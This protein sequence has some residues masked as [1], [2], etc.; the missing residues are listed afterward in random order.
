[1]F[2]SLY[3]GL[4][5]IPVTKFKVRLLHFWLV[6]LIFSHACSTDISTPP[7]VVCSIFIS[8]LS[9]VS[10]ISRK[11]GNIFRVVVFSV[12]LP[13]LIKDFAPC[14]YSR[15]YEKTHFVFSSFDKIP[16]IF[17]F[18]ISRKSSL[19]I[20]EKVVKDAVVGAKLPKNPP[21]PS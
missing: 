2:S 18:P 3:I 6:I 21:V 15:S 9:T 14:L 13:Q 4:V 7:A 10:S 5:N 17:K 11:V 16:S 8:S 12:T 20:S 1:M 19:F